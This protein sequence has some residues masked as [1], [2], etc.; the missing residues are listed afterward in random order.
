M[1][2]EILKILRC[3]KTKQK[4][5]IEGKVFKNGEFYSGTLVSADGKNNYPVR[6][7]IPRFVPISNYADNFGMQW[8]KFRQ[9]QLDSFSGQIISANRFWLATGWNPK[10][11]KGKWILDAGCGSG[12]FA[13]IALLS[14]AKVVAL[15]YSSAVDAC[16][17]NLKHHKNLYVIQGDIFNL[18]FAEKSF[19]YI[20]SLGVLQHTPNVSKAFASLPPLISSGGQLCVDFYWK[21]LKTIL[22]FKYLLRPITKRIPQDKLFSFI[23]L[24]I[25]FLLPVSQF[26]GKIPFIGKGLKRLIPIADYSGIFPLND[27]QL[28]EWALLDTFDWFSPQYDNP[29]TKKEV[30]NMFN[31]AGIKEIEIFH[32]GHL[33]GRGRKIS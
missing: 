16:L 26:L 10:D 15:D 5:K 8:N 17:K 30:L 3:P 32:A 28:K 24:V 11:L 6:N 14:G 1:K 33:V 19:P 22:H 2:Q 18:P 23:K 4:L 27:N 9:T 31:F 21:R 13:E 7:G 29:Q 20:Y 25:P 12:R